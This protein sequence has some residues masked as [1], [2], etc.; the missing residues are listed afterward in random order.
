MYKEELFDKAKLGDISI[1]T[2][3]AVSIVRDKLEYTPLHVLAFLGKVEILSHKDVSFVK[4]ANGNTPLHTLAS[5]S[6]DRCILDHPDIDTVKN[7]SGKTPKDL[8]KEK[9]DLHREELFDKAKLG[10]ISILSN[11]GTFIISGLYCD[12]PLHRLTVNISDLDLEALLAEPRIST[13]KDE[14]GDTPLHVMANIGKVEVISHKDVSVVKNNIGFTPLHLIAYHG[15]EEVLDHPDVGRVCDNVNNT[16]L[17][18]FAKSCCKRIR[19]ILNHCDVN[20]VR[21]ISGETPL[22]AFINRSDIL[23][24]NFQPDRDLDIRYENGKVISP[25]SF[26]LTLHIKLPVQEK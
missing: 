12:T 20:R 17:H 9:N 26:S 7:K 10:D 15:K 13:T 5:Y 22:Q 8:L 11:S 4:G 21:N 6:N 18:M 23:N 16:P 24:F 1:L 19:R 25:D 2:D 3:S 14:N